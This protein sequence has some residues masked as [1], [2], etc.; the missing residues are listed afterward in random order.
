[1]VQCRKCN[2]K[3]VVVYLAVFLKLY[4]NRK[5]KKMHIPTFVYT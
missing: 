1:M 2:S 4:L 5:Q 3:N